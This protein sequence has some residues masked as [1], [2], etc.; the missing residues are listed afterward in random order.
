MLASSSVPFPSSPA[1]LLAWRLAWMMRLLSAVRLVRLA[2]LAARFL[3][4]PV[5][6]S[7]LSASPASNPSGGRLALCGSPRWLLRFSSI[8]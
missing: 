1:V 5:P 7:R 2:V 8:I 3:M 4:S 6:V